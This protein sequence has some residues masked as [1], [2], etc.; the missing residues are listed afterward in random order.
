MD[1]GL[2]VRSGVNANDE[3]FCKDVISS[4]QACY[5]MP[6]GGEGGH[7]WSVG[8][9]GSIVYGLYAF[10]VGFPNFF[11]SCFTTP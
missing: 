2:S 8:R 10:T 4:P 5:E 11:N 1:V 6:H 7:T 9:E 3:W